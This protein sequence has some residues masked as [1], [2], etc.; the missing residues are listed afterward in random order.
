MR[1]EVLL[2]IL[3]GLCLTATGCAGSG[4]TAPPPEVEPPAPTEIVLAAVGDI[5]MHNTQ[6][7]A[8]KDS[9]SGEYDYS[10]FFQDISPYLT[11]ADVAVANLETTLAGAEKN[12]T[13]YPMFN[14][15]DSLAAALRGA[16]FDV[17][18]TANNHSLDRYED[19]VRRTLDVLDEHGLAHTGTFRTQQDRESPLLIDAAGIKLAF[20]AYT[21]GTNGIPLP[22]DKPYLVNLT[23]ETLMLADT[24]RARETEADLVIVSLHFGTEYVSTPSDSQ[25]ELA[26]KLVGA[27]ADIILGSHPHVLQPYEKISVETADGLSREG[28]VIYSLGNFI[29]GQNGLRREAGVIY[30]FRLRKDNETAQTAVRQVSY[31]PTWTHRYTENGRQQFR[32]VAVQKALADYENGRDSKLSNQA[33]MNLNKV[34]ADTTD[35]LGEGLEE[36][37]T[38]AAGNAKE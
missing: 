33:Y 13:G 21:Y 18:T 6:I 36:D 23:E 15:P 25:K 30:Y 1:R 24:A 22:P 16:G 17:L 5:M 31:V 2:I 38:T 28:W 35:L 8:G 10:R 19:G 29:S 9:V 20:L 12:Y 26:R 27:G 32:V 14:S 3:L 11:A 37:I 7:A 4:T 34:W